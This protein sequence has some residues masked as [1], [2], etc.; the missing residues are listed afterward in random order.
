MTISHG[1]DRIAA[2]ERIASLDVLRGI[3]I[4][5]ILFM[6]IPWMGYYAPS[7]SDPRL[8]SWTAFDRAGFGFM[9][10]LWGTQRGLLELLFG[11]G[12]MI[13]TRKAMT[14]D[15]P[16]AVADLHYRRNWL[17]IVL[18]LFNALVLLWGVDILLPYGMTALMLF[19]FR[20]LKVRTKFLLAALFLLGATSYGVNSYVER[21]EARDAAAQVAAAKAAHRPVDKKLAESAAAWDKAVK[22]AAPVAQNPEKQARMAEI[23]AT[24]TG[25]FGA[26]ALGAWSDWTG[27]F[28]AAGFFATLAEIAGTMLLGMALYEL[29]ILQGRARRSTYVALLLLGYGIGIPMRI[30]GFHE[31]LLFTPQPKIWWISQDFSRIAMTLGH[32]GLVQLLLLSGVGRALLWPFQAPGRM[33]LTTYLFTSFLT[34]WVLFPGFGLGWHGRWGFGG[35][36]SCAAIIILAEM[37]ATNAWMSRFETGPM[38]WIWKSLAYQRRMPFRRRPAEEPGLPP[39]AV[40]AE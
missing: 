1:T 14:P 16:V 2:G 30:A 7:M 34:M 21:V 5:F 27:L 38:E 26:Y 20:L 17:L 18:G 35:L 10:G 33:P 8:V 28:E 11:A 12:I 37:L 36:M 15:G 23:H 9:I 19:Q 40:P 39:D 4:L 31:I 22:N 3:A 25:P 6:N 32:I 24:R 29:G 13:M